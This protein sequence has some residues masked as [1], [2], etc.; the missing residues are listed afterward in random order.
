MADV[1]LNFSRLLFV[2]LTRSFGLA[3]LLSL[4]FQ[5]L[6]LYAPEKY[7]KEG[8]GLRADENCVAAVQAN[9]LPSVRLPRLTFSD[10]GLNGSTAPLISWEK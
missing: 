6:E 2:F 4:R 5:A 10:L 3:V 1:L 9:R 8:Q 7:Q